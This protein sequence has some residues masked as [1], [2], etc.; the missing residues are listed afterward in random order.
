M[1]IKIL[2][3]LMVLI[4]ATFL[5]LSFLPAKKIFANVT[6]RIRRKWFIVFYLIG[7]FVLGYLFFDIILIFS[8]P[9]P[10]EVV[11]G[12]VFLGGAFFVYIIINLSE[13]TIGAQQQSERA[14]ALARDDWENTFNTV[15]DMITV[16]DMDFNIVRANPVAKAILGL[17][18]QAG[19][20]L[21]KCFKAYHGAEKPP[22]MCQSC[23][24]LETGTPSTFELFEP[25]L[26]RHLEIR[27]M[28]RVGSDGQMLGLIHV[29]RDITKRK[30]AEE[31]LQENEAKLQAI[32]NTVGT[33]ILIIDSDTQIIIEANQTA[34]E[35]T[36]L[37]QEQIIGQL[38]HSLVCPAQEGKCPVKDLG[39]RV[40]QSESKLIHVDGH[41]KDI[42]KTVYP[43]TI[44]GK[45]CY[46][47]S[48]VDI[49]ERK[50]A[51]RQL[52]ESEQRYHELSIVDGLTQLYN[53]RHFYSQLKIEVD[54]AKRYEQ[55][56]TLFMLDIDRFK[57]FN[58]NYGHVEGDQVLCRLGQVMKRCLRETDFACRYGGEEFTI[59]LPMTTGAD[60]VVIAE[61]IRTE[62][63]KEVFSPVPGQN[64]H[65]TVSIGLVQYKPLE[66]IKAFVRRA[67]QRMYQGKKDGRDRVCSEP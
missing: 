59:I 58:D 27:A 12:G 61:R 64:V 47:E 8:L 33:G 1:A 66:E 67:D 10:V 11:T 31:A 43:I 32:F 6:D 17:R 18:L 30:R 28:P 44:K 34:I 37:S 21:E 53:S 62:F 24:V 5:L 22:S 36:G 7:F 9:F 25:Y 35:M 50:E 56:L 45:D 29:V 3:I 52:Q 46:L 54:R 15:T 48:F 41:Q 20:P 51:V 55:P 23:Q 49:T 19:I 57:T 60:S 38:C 40:D 42:L 65:V 16:Q 4:G 14:I 39:Q 2:S 13:I 26:D 63:K